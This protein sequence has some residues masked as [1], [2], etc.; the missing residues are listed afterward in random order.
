MGRPTKYKEEYNDQV[1]KL[2]LLG[3]TD[4]DFATFFDVTETTINNWKLDR[5]NGFIESL[6]KGRDQ[7]DSKVAESLYKRATGYDKDGKHYP[8]ETV[9]II[10]WLKNRQ[11]SRWK[12]KPEE[13]G[14][15]NGNNSIVIRAPKGVEFKVLPTDESQI[16]EERDTEYPEGE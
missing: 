15:E 2:A 4:A 13:E 11:R 5:K 7:A 9:A 10:Y 12:D 3:Y 6:K 16:N 14:D 1:Y 8:A